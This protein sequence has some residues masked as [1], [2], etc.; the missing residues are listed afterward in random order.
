MRERLIQRHYSFEETE[1]VPVEGH[2]FEDG[3][4]HLDG[5]RGRVDLPLAI[6]ADREPDGRLTELRLYF[7]NWPL[8]GRHVH[9]PPL[10][11]PPSQ[12]P[13]LDVVDDYERAL[14]AGNVDGALSAFEPTGYIQE[15]AGGRHVHAGAPG[16]R[17]FHEWL[18]ANGGGISRAQCAVID[19]GRA[20]ALE[21]NVLGWGSAELA[22]AAGITVYVRG[23]TGKLAAARTYDDVVPAR[24]RDQYAGVMAVT[25]SPE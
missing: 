10:L 15:A 17:A 2:G 6:V 21:Y 8:T 19:D 11:Q 12:V 18:F 1:R 24:A 5:E 9:R 20:C 4:L 16:L 22:P 23:E 14:A 3:V 25:Q 7:S 13:V